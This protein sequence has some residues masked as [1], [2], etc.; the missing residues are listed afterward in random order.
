MKSRFKLPTVSS[1]PAWFG[2]L[3]LEVMLLIA[4]AIL[5]VVQVVL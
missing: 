1:L 3:V 4:M 5:Q 2:I